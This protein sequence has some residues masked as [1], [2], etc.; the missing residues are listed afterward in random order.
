MT[1]AS[2]QTIPAGVLRLGLAKPHAVSAV[3]AGQFPPRRD[4]Q[5]EAAFLQRASF[6]SEMLLP[7]KGIEVYRAMAR[8]AEDVIEMVPARKRINTWA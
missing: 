7:R 3:S 2:I 8:E 6:V 5:P 1:G 4:R